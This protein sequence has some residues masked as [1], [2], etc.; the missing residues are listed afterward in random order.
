[1]FPQLLFEED[2][3]R[4]FKKDESPRCSHLYR[5]L[6]E[7]VGFHGIYDPFYLAVRVFPFYIIPF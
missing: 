6:L 5:E 4:S 3:G 7:R 2:F 1:M